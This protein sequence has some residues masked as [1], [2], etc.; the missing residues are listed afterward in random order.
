[1]FRSN[2][3]L[4]LNPIKI[5]QESSK[6]YDKSVPEEPNSGNLIANKEKDSDLNG[7]ETNVDKD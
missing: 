6:V 2:S 1:M 4:F 5:K 7:D 3:G